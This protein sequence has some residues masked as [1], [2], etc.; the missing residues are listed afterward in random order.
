MIPYF[1]NIA[2]PH[3]IDPFCYTK[4]GFVIDNNELTN[5]FNNELVSLM[6]ETT[7]KKNIRFRSYQHFYDLY[8]HDYSMDQPPV[9]MQYFEDN[10]WKVFNFMDSEIMALYK[11]VL[12]INKKSIPELVIVDTN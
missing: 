3:E 11:Q 9:S 2:F 5:I 10:M 1:I 7:N 8:Y 12:S 4:T 6:I